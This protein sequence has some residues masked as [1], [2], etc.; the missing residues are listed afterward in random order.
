MEV[1]PQNAENFETYPHHLVLLQ[2]CLLRS[3]KKPHQ[4][5]GTYIYFS[6]KQG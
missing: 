3:T 1:Y 6:R 5:I 4:D 2:C